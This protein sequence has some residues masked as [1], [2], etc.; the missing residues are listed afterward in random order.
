MKKVFLRIRPFLLISAMAAVVFGCSKDAEDP[1]FQETKL[2]SSEVKTILETVEVSSA[3]DDVVREL[4]TADKSGTTAKM[5]SCYQVDYSDTGFSVSFD[6]CSPQEDDEIYNG[7]VNVVYGTEDDSFAFVIHFDNLMVGDIGLD[8]SRSFTIDGEQENSIIFTVTSD[9]TVT[10][11]D[12]RV[13]TE[14]GS[15]TF[16]VLFSEELGGGKITLDG[17]WFLTIDGNTYS[18]VISDLLETNFDCEYVA[19]GLMLLNKNGLEVS[20][21]FG[22]GSCDDMAELA[23][24]DG[25]KENISLKK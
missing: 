13:I 25:T 4:F 17:D 7:S 8:G 11:P 22:D 12:N 24:P 19:K 14:K 23:Y 3:A 21:D 1:L 5:G 16:T 10:M 18:V 6:N 20:V 15:K 9:M 2:S